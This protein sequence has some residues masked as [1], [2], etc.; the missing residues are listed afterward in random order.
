MLS[1][2]LIEQ[3]MQRRAESHLETDVLIVDYYRIRRKLAYPF[4]PTQLYVPNMEVPDIPQYPWETWFS[5]SLEE[6]ILSL[7]W[8]ATWNKD[9]RYQQRCLSCLHALLNWETYKKTKEPSLCMGHIMRIFW[10]ALNLWSWIP[11]VDCQAIRNRLHDVV[12]NEIEHIDVRY[13]DLDSI[14]TLMT[15]PQW[16]HKIHNIQLIS[17]IGIALAAHGSNHTDFKKLHR[18]LNMALNAWLLLR[19]D[20]VVE[21]VAYDGYTL[22]FFMNWVHTLPLIEQSNWVDHHQMERLFEES[23]AL[24]A[25]GQMA[26]VVE[27]SDVEPKEM[28]FHINGHIK[29]FTLSA[30]PYWHWYIE[31]IPLEWITADGLGWLYQVVDQLPKQIEGVPKSGLHDCQ[32]VRVIRNGWEAEHTAVAIAASNSPMDHIHHDNGHVAVATG[33]VWLLTDPGYQQYI[34]NSERAFT[35]GTYAHNSPIINGYSAEHKKVELEICQ[36][37]AAISELRLDLTG[38][39]GDD[40]KVEKVVRGVWYVQGDQL[41]IMDWIQADTPVNLNYNWLGHSEA[42]WWEDSGRVQLDCRGNRLQ[43]MCLTH[44]TVELT[45][46]RGSRGQL[47][48]MYHIED[49]SGVVW[50][51]ILIGNKN[52]QTPTLTANNQS[53]ILPDGTELQAPII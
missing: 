44:P 13:G 42:A 39:Y 23:Y 25:P 49:Y 43:M 22:D 20:G 36:H 26:H 16:R 12:N 2:Q 45:R 47:S 21:G 53:C 31:H 41:I 15:H 33:G 24:G 1:K 5:W 29:R 40:A 14:E 50:W 28:P 48:A 19:D 35:I 30:F 18:Y 51:Y 4:P 17:T 7:G 9:V 52:W 38:G 10:T 8:T 3:E 11:E 32:Y 34:K 6:S 46:L 27:L 37:D